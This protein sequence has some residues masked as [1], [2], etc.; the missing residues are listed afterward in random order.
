MNMRF[1]TV[2]L[3]IFGA[4]GAVALAQDQPQAARLPRRPRAAFRQTSARKSYYN[5]TMGHLY[6]QEFESS[7]HAEDAAKAIDFYK[8]AYALD[9][10]QPGNRRGPCRSLFSRASLA[11]GDQRSGRPYSPQSQ[12]HFRAP[13]AGADLH[14]FPW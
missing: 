12:R 1:L 7:G 5:V 4:T 8:K 9:P 3:L 10:I 2:A 13:F 11:R 6:E 14:P